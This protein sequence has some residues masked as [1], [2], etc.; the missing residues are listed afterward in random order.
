MTAV[1]DA[2][3]E[4]LETS[5]EA[6]IRI[7]EICESTGINYGSVYHHFGSRDGVIEAAYEMI[8]TR[9]AEQ[10]LEMLHEANIAVSTF[11][12]YVGAMAPL[13]DIVSNG[14]ARRARRALRLRIVAA[15]QTRPPLRELI[16]QAQM[17]LTDELTQIVRYGQDRGWL[18]NDLNAHLIAVLMQALVFGRNL[19]DAS[20]KPVGDD[21][22]GGAMAVVFS[23]VL[24]L[25]PGIGSA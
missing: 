1:L 5:D 2:V 23:E 6:S 16:A 11:E 18:R 15:S 10:D 25:S 8:F 17:R 7:P 13:V 22:W 24:H 4:R 19:D 20:A 9:L 21:Q 12:A 3:A 14:D